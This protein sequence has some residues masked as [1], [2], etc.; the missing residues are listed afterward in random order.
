MKTD[1][2]LLNNI[3]IQKDHPSLYFFYFNILTDGVYLAGG[4]ARSFIDKEEII[5]DYDLFF[6]N[7]K[8]YLKTADTL[9]SLG[10]KMVFDCPIGLLRTYKNRDMKVQL[11]TPNRPDWFFYPE[12]VLESFDFTATQFLLFK[13][14]LITTKQAI[15]DV[16]KKILRI[17][18]ITHPVSTFKRVIKYK[19]KGYSFSEEE[20]MKLVN[21]F[22]NTNPMDLDLRWYID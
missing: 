1:Y 6:S 21:Y 5:S 2:I 10:F 4:A 3:K 13:D 17:H 8:S 22:R 12:S 19:E 18:K 20:L 16:R 11:I 14:G 15:S 7:E 9:S